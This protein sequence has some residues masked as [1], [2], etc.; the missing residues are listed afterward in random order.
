MPNSISARG[1][2]KL[3]INAVFAFQY[4]WIIRHRQVHCGTTP[5]Y[6]SSIQ[7]KQE[8]PG[9]FAH[10]VLF[11]NASFIFTPCWYLTFN[12][13]E[14]WNNVWAAVPTLQTGMLCAAEDRESK[15]HHRWRAAWRSVCTAISCGGEATCVSHVQPALTQDTPIIILLHLTKSKPRLSSR[16]HGLLFLPWWTGA[17]DLH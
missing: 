17:V 3:K 13:K 2:K 14:K 1:I 15:V 9:D 7:R 16:S 11:L 4:F 8:N 5:T 12:V 6:P 10:C